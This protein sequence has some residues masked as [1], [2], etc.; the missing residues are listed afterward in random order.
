MEA[1]SLTMLP[2][3][4]RLNKKKDIERVFREGK[5]FKEDF[6][7]LKMIKNNL[8]NSRF[9]FIVT[10]KVSKKATL[11]NKVKRRLRELVRLKLKKIKKGLDFILLAKPGIEKKDFQEVDEALNKL[12]KKTEI[13]E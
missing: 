4:N 2:K 1:N 3:V 5:G 10:Q 9:A 8:E 12:F 13:I 11:R 7:I 6:L